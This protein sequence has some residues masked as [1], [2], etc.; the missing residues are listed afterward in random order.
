LLVLT[1]ALHGVLAEAKALG[2][3]VV[4]VRQLRPPRRSPGSGDGRSP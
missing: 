4:E 3:V 1:P 2:L